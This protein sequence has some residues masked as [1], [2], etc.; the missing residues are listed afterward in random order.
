M[1]TSLKKVLAVS[2]VV[3]SAFVGHAV[4][5]EVTQVRQRY[6]WNGIVDIDY[7]VT[8]GDG[9]SPLT[10]AEDQLS[11]RVINAETSTTN[12]AGALTP[13]YPPITAGSHR[14]SWNANADGISYASKSVT[15]EMTLTHCQTKYLV[16]DVSQ[17]R[18]VDS[19]PVEYLQEVPE[20]GFKSQTYKTDKI[21]LRLIPPGTFVM[22]SPDGEA[23]RNNARE[24]QH[25]VLLTNAYYIGLFE[26]TQAQYK[27][28]MNGAN[29]SWKKGDSLPVDTMTYNLLRGA[30]AKWPVD[31]SV[32]STSF[33]GILRDKTGLAFDLP[34]EAEWEY[35]CRAGTSSAYNNGGSTAADLALVGNS[36]SKDQV[37]G[38]GLLPNA[39]GLYDMHGNVS[40]LCLD[41][42]AAEIAPSN[43]QLVAPT[44]AA[45]GTQ[46]VLRGG[47]W[48]DKAAGCRSA[49]RGSSAPAGYAGGGVDIGFRIALPVR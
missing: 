18:M 41:W 11:I 6:P 9:E 20:G 47:S 40:E 35:A 2:T 34:T 49:T 39:F 30:N 3:F 43:T 24:A 29:P 36:S 15:V 14:V 44:G 28:V 27:H 32:G 1:N 10:F 45:T 16:V 42:F 13:A 12:W 25:S 19:W 22:G 48:Y 5:V 4:S 46:R 23:G 38:G 21:V 8:F 26:V 33:F 7:T 31:N 37:E 17:G